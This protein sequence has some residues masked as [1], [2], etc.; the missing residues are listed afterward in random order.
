MIRRKY[1][2]LFVVSFTLL[3]VGCDND[4]GHQSPNDEWTAETL[5]SEAD[6]E[7]SGVDAWFRS[8]TI[9]D[10]IFSRMWLKSW[11]EDI[12]INKNNH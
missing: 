4:L 3:L 11:K 2:L 9:S 8:E 7:R 5:V 12:N 10:Q 1:L 6:V